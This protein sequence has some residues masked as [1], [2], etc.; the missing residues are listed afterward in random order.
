MT[1]EADLIVL[2]IGGFPPTFGF[3]MMLT[4]SSTYSSL[5]SFQDCSFSFWDALEKILK[6]RCIFC[7]MSF[8]NFHT[9]KFQARKCLI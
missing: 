2:I 5:D 4:F 8:D 7:V 6:H 1:C 9:V 3:E